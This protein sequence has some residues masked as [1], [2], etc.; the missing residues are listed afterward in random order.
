MLNKKIFSTC[1]CILLIAVLLLTACSGDGN[2]SSSDTSSNNDTSGDV[3]AEI[4]NVVSV[5]DSS[6]G[7]GYDNSENN[8][9][10]ADTSAPADN[11]SD[12]VSTGE[13][14]TSKPSGNDNETSKNESN[15][16]NNNNSN[17]AEYSVY[18]VDG[19]GNP[20]A[21]IIVQIS[22]KDYSG[23]KTTSAKGVAKFTAKKGEYTIKFVAPGKDYYYDTEKCTLTES[24]TSVTVALLEKA[25]VTG[26]VNAYSTKLDDYKEFPAYEINEGM[27]FAPLSA[28]EMTYYIFVPLRSGTFEVTVSADTDVELG[29]Y[30][31][32]IYVH[33]YSLF[34][35]TEGKLVFEIHNYHIG[36]T[37]DTT[38]SYVIGVKTVDGDD[39]N[40]ILSVT[41]TGDAPW[42]V[43]DE[44]WQ[45]PKADEKYLVK[46]EGESGKT[47]KDI[48]ILS[49]PVIVF[50][51]TDGYYHYGS[52]NGP[53]VLVRLDSDAKYLNASLIDICN[54][55]TFGIYVYNK[56]GSFAYKERY[57]E[58]LLEY[59]E[60][61]DAN[62]VC[63]LNKQLAEIIKAFGEHKGWWKAAAAPTYIF[64]S[65]PAYKYP[66][67]AWLFC[68]CYYE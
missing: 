61:C 62:G 28:G 59:K 19:N 16:N 4:E 64:G 29:Y 7:T 33:Q 6:A 48:D 36:S 27:L 31:M 14:E 44:P 1:L 11:S 9:P 20:I 12:D 47:L 26:S 55:S 50:N 23:M 54:T 52:E 58:L 22:G 45:V 51:E 65:A 35:V 2:E 8:T 3:S 15:N 41:R 42:S 46:Y 57:N 63:P 49:N 21:N 53:L 25:K 30:G 38:S 13:E 43:E 39:G 24:V 37:K 40:C 60:I 68:C 56:D 66:D 67:I 18:A 17:E 32:P 34:D 5:P 10:P